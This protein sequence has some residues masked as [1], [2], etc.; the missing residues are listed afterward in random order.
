MEQ[1]NWPKLFLLG[2][3][4][5]GRPRIKNHLRYVKQGKVPLTYW[6]SDDFDDPELLDFGVQSWAYTESGHG[7]TGLTELNSILGASHGFDTVKPLRLFEKI[8][9]IWSPHDGIVLDPFAGSGT[10]AHAVLDL[11][12]AT[13]TKRKFILIEK[14]EGA[15]EYAKT[16][17][18]ERVKRVISGERIQRDGTLILVEPLPGGFDNW[19]LDEQVDA[20]A[21]LAM[22]REELIDVIITS[23]WE[24]D[25][26]RAISAV[27]RFN[28]P[29]KHLVGKTRLDEGFF[30][31]WNGDDSVGQLDQNTYM[32]L[33]S[34]AKMEGVKTPYHVYA[35]F[36][37]YQT[38]KV[39]F[40]QIPDKILMHLGLNEN[41][42]KFNNEVDE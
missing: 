2:A 38:T 16:L 17:T 40:Y 20:S 4:N 11:N 25:R 31:I 12:N 1:D 15:D 8:I 18:R 5:E 21:I 14:G 37:V 6:S 36:Q 9:Q 35:R 26:H 28:K 27:E 19:E 32:E 7:Q 23:H 42:D 41:S 29:Y 39:R 13:D 24:D 33:L 10:T 34:E 22:R 30:I 3:N